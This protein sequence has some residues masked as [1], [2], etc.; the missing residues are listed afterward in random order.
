PRCIGVAVE[1]SSAARVVVVFRKRR[2][3]DDG[4]RDALIV[5]FSHATVKAVVNKD[6]FIAPGIDR[7][8][9]IAAR[10]VGAGGCIAH[11]VAGVEA[12]IQS[13]VSEGSNKDLLDGRRDIRAGV[14]GHG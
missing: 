2:I 12:T 14:G 13:V 11:V 9:E 1:G 3:E 6:S 10:I 4:A 8:N 5:G 7:T